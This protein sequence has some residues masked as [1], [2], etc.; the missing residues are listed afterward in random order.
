MTQE[1]RGELLKELRELV[2]AWGKKN[3]IPPEDGVWLMNELNKIAERSYELLLIE[4]KLRS[5]RED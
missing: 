2:G 5:A 4:E 1:K 3:Q